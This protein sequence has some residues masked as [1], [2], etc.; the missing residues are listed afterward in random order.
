MWIRRIEVRHC[1]GIAEGA[2]DLQR[3]FNVLHGPNELGKSTLVTALRAAFLLPARS[4]LASGL[5]DWNAQEPPE[6]SVTFEDDDGRVW[7]VRK[8]FSASGGKAFL[9]A[10]RDGE[11]FDTDA[12]G[13]EVDGKLQEILRWGIEAPGGRGRRG[14]PSS[15]I[16]TA[17]LPDQGDVEA[18]LGRSLA[19][20]ADESGRDRLTEALHA[21]AEDPRLKQI[22]DVVQARVDE[23]FTPTGRKRGGRGSP[24]RGLVDERRRAEDWEREV[25]RQSDETARVRTRIEEVSGQLRHGRAE[26]DRLREGIARNDARVA[27]EMAFDEAEEQFVA[28]EATIGQLR[29]NEKAVADANDRLRS[30]A[31]KRK[32]FAE[33]LAD[34]D[35][36]VETARANLHELESDDAEQRRRL[37]EQERENARLELQ[38]QLAAHAR[39][40]EQ[41]AEIRD[42]GTVIE[43][44]ARD[45]ERV[46]AKLAEKRDLLEKAAAANAR[47]EEKIEALRLE[48]RVGRYRTAAAST[49]ALE[50]QRADTLELAR[51]ATEGEA[52][53]AALRDEANSLNA[54]DE[55]ELDRLRT[56]EEDARLAAAKLSVGLTAQLTLETAIET[57]VD[58]DG[59]ARTLTPEAGTATEFE[60]EREL[61]IELSGVA[62]LRV[63]GGGRDLVEEAAE[64]GARWKAASSPV[65]SRTGC[66]TLD[67]LVALRQ[68]AEGLRSEAHE[69]SREAEAAG[70]RAEGRNDIERRLATARAERDRHAGD[71]A[72]RRDEG[73][74]V[75]ELVATF[76]AA[77]DQAALGNDIENLQEGLQER[78]SLAERMAVEIDGDARELEDKR[79]RREEQEAQLAGRSAALEDWK[80]VLERA[81][82]ERGRLDRELDAVHAQ[83]GELRAEIA[84]E[85]GEARSTLNGLTE[86]QTQQQTAL[87]QADGALGKARTELARLE[88]ETP[89][90]IENAKSLDLDALRAARDE[91]REALSALPPLGP[92]GADTAATREEAELADRRIRELEAELRKA[93]GALEQTGGQQ[94]DEQRE[95]A[96][97]ASDALAR[98][99]QELE[100]DYQAWQLLQQTLSEAEREGAAH[101]GSALVQPV[102]QRIASLTAGRYGELAL[103]PQ[104]D[105]TGIELAGS[106]REFGALSVGTRE[107]IALVLRI[108][109]AEALGTFLVLDD[110]L[111]QTD[112]TRMDWTRRLLAEVAQGVQVIVLTCHPLDYEA[113]SPDHVVDLSA[114]L[115]RSD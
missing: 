90:L 84:D 100:L 97:E 26:R 92:E 115:S 79:A 71:L 6:V 16:T 55:A 17:L 63:R 95:Q 58:V 91:A 80:A 10:S 45:I 35:T 1:A 29:T 102:S 48:R 86:T 70:L 19:D 87:E 32:E 69:L 96:R 40:V 49:D 13:R 54:P 25:R 98:R 77:L 74:T 83:L 76:D 44:G 104:L 24:W 99:E 113:E 68:R 105:A 109:I 111:T 93:E 42:L 106:E 67:E 61:A 103:G 31:T 75:E 78:R 56:A 8:I 41:A 11:H 38:Q 28:A 65:F 112:D 89:I 72:T 15:L 46:E 2:V 52:Q 14:M 62:T 27:A 53:A 108:A 22:V 101:L 57:A 51:R 94:L 81:E 39:R 5:Q 50:K 12:R 33:T 43:A 7:R 21:L 37:R 85:V 23:A 110:Q 9:D 82:E 3:G 66:S 60:A 88:G 114:L 30:L 107:Q 4:S 59:D 36:R 73:Q 64:A 34:T 47:D 18:I 20:D